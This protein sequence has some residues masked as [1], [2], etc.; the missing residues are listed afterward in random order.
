[1]NAIPHLGVGLGYRREMH[2]ATVEHRDEIDFLEIVTDAYLGSPAT[3]A[4]LRD[5][6]EEF[7]LVPHGLEMSVG[8][9]QPLDLAYVDGVATVA[10]AVDA[11]W[12]SD[13]LCFTREEGVELGTLTPVRRTMQRARHI[14]EKSKKIQDYLGRPFLLE[15]IS[16]YIDLPGEL[17][18]A[19]MLTEVLDRSGC[20]LLLDLTN[21]AVNAR[22]HHFSA[23]DMLDSLPLERVVQVHLAGSAGR[24]DFEGL[25]LDS[26][27]GPISDEVF[28]LL[29]RLVTR[30][31]PQAV[32]IERD[33]NFPD[34]FGEILADLRRARAILEGAAAHETR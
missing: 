4:S 1:M 32:M 19:E 25:H 6:K 20:G 15:N 29:A 9:E 23:Q 33:D 10:D 24:Q 27:D 26:H 7:V 5:L 3:H 34:D 12:V 30:C 31:R 8:S 2:D 22:N 14:A 17:S 28:Q 13:H 11:P 16:Y 18:E 21:I